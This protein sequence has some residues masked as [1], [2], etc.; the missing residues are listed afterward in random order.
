MLDKGKPEDVM[1]SVKGAQVSQSPLWAFCKRARSTLWGSCGHVLAS[2]PFSFFCLTLFLVPPS[3][4][5]PLCLQ[6]RL[7]TVPLSG[8]YNK[9]G[10]KVRL[11]F[12]LEQ[13]QLWIGT[14]GTSLPLSLPGFCLWHPAAVRLWSGSAPS[15]ESSLSTLLC[16]L[17][18]FDFGFLCSPFVWTLFPP[19]FQSHFRAIKHWLFSCAQNQRP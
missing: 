6:E 17:L 14:K 19:S 15:S 8:M 10:G 3:L 4:T 5:V 9:S 18:A 1:P 7:P 12:K 11:T 13:D 16:L 2:C